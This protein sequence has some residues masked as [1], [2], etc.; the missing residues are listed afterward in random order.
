MVAEVDL[1][2]GALALPFAVD[3]D[4]LAKFRM[5]D[6]HADREAVLGDAGLRRDHSGG[7]S[8][9]AVQVAQQILRDLGV[10]S[11]RLLANH[12]RHYIGLSGFGIVIDETELLEG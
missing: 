4:A 11:I 9:A 5:P 1:H 3:D 8:V 12:Q 7:R 10:A 6:R 2:I